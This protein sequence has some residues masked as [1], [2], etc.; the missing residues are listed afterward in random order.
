MPVYFEYAMKVSLCLA[1]IFL[2]YTLLLK[3]ITYY[4]WNRYFLLIF[5]ILSFIVPFINVSA[6]VQAK[7]LHNFSFVNQI[8]SIVNNQMPVHVNNQGTFNYL[9][10]LSAIYILVSAILFVRLLVQLLSIEKIRSKATL[11]MDSEV[12]IFHLA[13]PVIP[14]SF[15][16]SIF[17]NQHN[18]SE[19]E[20]QKI[21][22]HEQV[23]VQQKHTIDILIS[24]IICIV[25][26]FNPFAWLIKKAVRENL[27]F[28]A[29]DTVMR[30]GV[31]RKNYQYL[32]LK[33]TGN[34]PFSVTNSL[35]FSSLKNRILMMNKTKTSMFHL[36]KFLLLAPI[37]MLLLFAFRGSKGIDSK[38]K[39]EE[40]ETY[41]LST[42]TY[43]I[44]DAKVKA[45][46]FKEQDKCLLKPGQLLNLTLVYN[47]RNRLKSLLEKN[48]YDNLKSNAIRFLIDTASVNNS[49]S[50]E[51]NINTEP[52]AVSL[53]N[54]K[55]GL[56]NNPIVTSGDNNLN[57]LRDLVKANFVCRSPSNIHSEKFISYPF[58]NNSETVA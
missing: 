38:V 49:F 57:Y 10:I 39:T 3:R 22:E 25:N 21:I 29:D 35:K 1:I 11:I 50:V 9:E 18:Y 19:N 27:E 56:F 51:I 12:K 42:L 46:V 16:N 5:S 24:E 31:N 43:S 36:L 45:I 30:K 53:V 37:I 58:L 28:I 6:F 14:F 23:H 34:L 55:T 44:P 41:T 54:K 26:W 47:E 40:T 4:T 20:L 33:V 13:Q 17:I 32:L 48:G 15:F 52:A 7:Q 8:P 2:F